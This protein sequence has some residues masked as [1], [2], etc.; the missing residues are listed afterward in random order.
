[1]N[2]FL[3]LPL[4][5]IP[6]IV[7]QLER[8]GI[9]TAVLNEVLEFHLLDVQATLGNDFDQFEDP[10]SYLEIVDYIDVLARAMKFLCPKKDEAA[11]L[12][13]SQIADDEFFPTPR[14]KNKG[15]GTTKKGPTGI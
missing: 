12:P 5:R 10:L 3:L 11:D 8:A 13:S 1:M 9:D 7:R 4:E 2:F 15:K 6:S 14:A